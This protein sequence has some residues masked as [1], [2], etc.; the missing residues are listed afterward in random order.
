M[1]KMPKA[2]AVEVR[3]LLYDTPLTVA[4]ILGSEKGPLTIEDIKKFLGWE[5]EGD[6]ITR[7]LQSNPT[8]KKTEDGLVDKQGRSVPFDFLFIDEEG[9]KIICWHNVRNRPFDEAHARK[10]AQDMLN[11][12]WQF[13][14]EAIIISQYGTILSGQHRLI[15]AVLAEQMRIG[16]NK[17]H[18]ESIGRTEPVTLETTVVFGVKDE[19]DVIKTLDNVKQRTLADTIFTSDIFK[20]LTD[21]NDRKDCSRALDSAI[22]FLWKRT[23]A[24][25]SQFTKYQTHSESQDFLARHPKLTHAVRHLFEEN[26]GRYRGISKVHLAPGVCSG[27]CYLQAASNTEE[28]TKYLE[29]RSEKYLD[30]GLWNKAKEFYVEL[31]AA[32]AQWQEWFDK[33]Q[34]KGE[35]KGRKPLWYLVEALLLLQDEDSLTGGRE[36]EK[37]YVLAKA[38]DSYRTG[39]A[40][41][42]DTLI[43]SGHVLK[44]S[45]IGGVMKL[46]ERP[47]FGGIDQGPKQ[48]GDEEDSD[49]VKQQKKEHEA[50]KTIKRV[51]GEVPSP[52][53]VKHDKDGKPPAPVLKKTENGAVH[54]SLKA[55]LERLRGVYPNKALLFKAAGGWTMWAGDA[56][57]GQ[58]LL[59][60]K[61][62]KGPEGVVKVLIPEAKLAEATVKFGK[63]KRGFVQLDSNGKPLSNGKP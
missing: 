21:R 19:A 9:N 30:M 56:L 18:W 33:P 35:P 36:A 62:T 14:G 44:H 24:G 15:G 2:K 51:K 46:D 12:H 37:M 27:A 10:L 6:F 32:H 59:D 7:M 16:K 25:E 20:D 61:P 47:L 50:Q 48:V 1:P 22:D 23:N 8:L 11:G 26:K 40:P 5:T 42:R 17:N 31:V 63:A 43:I 38:W 58:K 39:K 28:T 4:R 13:N 3:E 54:G 57:I 52:E 45:M 55:E 53:P 29:H 49:E 41:P 60:L 34:H